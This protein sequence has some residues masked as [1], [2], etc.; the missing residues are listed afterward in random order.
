MQQFIKQNLIYSMTEKIFKYS[1]I[2]FIL[3]NIWT[4]YLFFGYL[5]EEKGIFNGFGLLIDFVYSQIFNVVFGSL[6]LLIRAF[7][8]FRKIN[9][10]PLKIN[11]FYILSGIFSINIFIIWLCSIILQ[12]IELANELTTI[13]GV[14]S[15]LIGSFIILDI[16][17][18][19]FKKLTIN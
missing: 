18:L 4:L 3:I 11:F 8:Y 7:F 1:T 10:N 6:L 12:F 19:N 16:Y 14:S 15:L 13:L 9:S 2:S 17:K 5:S